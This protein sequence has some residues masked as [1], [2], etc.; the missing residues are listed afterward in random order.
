MKTTYTQINVPF[1]NEM[2][3]AMFDCGKD[4][5]SRFK[6]IGNVGDQFA[7][8]H[9]ETMEQRW[10][11]I[12]AIQKHT[13]GEVAMHMYKKEGF[14]SEEDFMR[15][16]VKMHPTRVT[17]THQVFVHILKPVE[18]EH[19]TPSKTGQQTLQE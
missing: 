12:D 15:F 3:R 11:M 16:W 9:P 1:Y 8:T 10:W 4:R 19:A 18:N 7:L 5:T 17:P 14:I 2:I 6:K 13:L